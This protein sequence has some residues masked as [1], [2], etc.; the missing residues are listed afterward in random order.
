MNKDLAMFL[1]VQFVGTVFYY[2]LSAAYFLPFPSTQVLIGE[3]IFRLLLT[4]FGGLY[5]VLTLVLLIALKASKK[6]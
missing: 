1:L 5:L 3:P 2:V 6:T 4:G